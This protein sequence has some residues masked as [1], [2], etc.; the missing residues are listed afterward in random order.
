[1]AKVERKAQF[2]AK[3]TLS[4]KDVGT[5]QI[6]IFEWKS[7]INGGYIIRAKIADAGLRYLRE[8]LDIMSFLS[9]ARSKP[10]EVKFRLEYPSE[11]PK[12]NVTK[13]PDR[14]AYITDFDIYG[15]A[16][17][18]GFEFVAVDPPTWYL[19]A[20]KGDGRVYTGRISDVIK[21]TVEDFT[22]GIK[23]TVTKTSDDENGKWGM[24]RQDPQTFI[25]SL[26]D[27]SANLTPQK[28]NWMVASRDDRIFIQEQNEFKNHRRQ[29]NL[30]NYFVSPGSSP[31]IHDYAVLG[32]TFLTAFQNNMVSQ[33]ISAVSG[34]FIDQQ[35]DKDKVF[36]TD[37]LTGKKLNT[38]TTSM[39]SFSKPTKDWATSIIAVP[40]LSGGEIGKPYEEWLAGR[41]RNLYISSLPLIFR[42][43]LTVKGDPNYHDS[44]ELG[45]STINIKWQDVDNMPFFLTGRWLVYGFHHRMSRM[46]TPKWFTDVYIY[47]LDHDAASKK[48]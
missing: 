33:G 17:G 9:D 41:A 48:M 45:A 25:Q 32:S 6:L 27:W 19:N 46:S 5:N 42:V 16:S 8:N 24:M 20:G 39:E 18:A 15:D 11:S 22:D 23:V 31:D 14:I 26:L 35:T 40:E 47:R 30:N 29:P 34:K 21:Q 1:M 4:D 3:V 44:V 12:I 7:F 10:T 38:K 2:V 37:E 13:T 43:R 36:I 28:T